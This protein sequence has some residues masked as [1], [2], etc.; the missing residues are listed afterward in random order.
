MPVSPYVAH[1][2]DHIGHATLLS[3]AASAIIRD[4]A[5]R[6]LLIR[7]GGESLSAPRGGEWSLPG[8]GMEPGESIAGCVVREAFEE[9]GLH[10][11][12]V[13][14]IGVY[15]DPAFQHVTYPNGDQVH[16]VSFSFECRVVRG[17]LAPDG[18][19]SL[20]VA[21]VSPSAL[22]ESIWPGHTIRIQ[23]ALAARESAFFR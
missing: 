9:T 11:E 20:E 16:Y 3:A 13:R 23:D 12:P 4:E 7:R 21:Y 2:R 6:V 15:S 10:V 19:E 17:G 14:L 18:D 8:G 22:P 5:G 1:L